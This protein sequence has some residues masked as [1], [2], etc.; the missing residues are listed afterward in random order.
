MTAFDGRNLMMKNSFKRSPVLVEGTQLQMVG[1]LDGKMCKELKR[2][3]TC[4][5]N[6]MVKLTVK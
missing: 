3:A 6:S 1:A 5:F 4:Q 2:K